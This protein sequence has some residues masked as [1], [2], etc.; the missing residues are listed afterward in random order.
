MLGVNQVHHLPK[1]THFPPNARTPPRPSCKKRRR[2]LLPSS[3]LRR[4]GGACGAASI[5]NDY[6]S[7]GFRKTDVSVYLTMTFL[8]ACVPSVSVT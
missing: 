5:H 1:V 8:T 4:P 6:L 3:A 2:K 7:Q